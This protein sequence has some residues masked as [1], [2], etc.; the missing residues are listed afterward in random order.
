MTIHTPAIGVH[1]ESRLLLS[2]GRLRRAFVKNAAV[3]WSGIRLYTRH[4]REN[5]NLAG[6]LVVV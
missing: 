1:V 3:S 2:G 4:G 6:F 5:P